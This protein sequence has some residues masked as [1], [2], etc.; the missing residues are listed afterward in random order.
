[1]VTVEDQEIARAMLLLLERAKMVVE[2]AGAAAI[3][4]LATDQVAAL[5]TGQVVA[6]T[7][8]EVVA[9]GTNI[10]ALLSTRRPP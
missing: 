10:G 2:P 6:L 7:T 4:A 8:A 5:T 1:M 9:L 3:A